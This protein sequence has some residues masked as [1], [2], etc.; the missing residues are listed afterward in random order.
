MEYR[1]VLEQAVV[2]RG[3][4]EPFVGNHAILVA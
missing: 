3:K 2:S 4:E 1:V